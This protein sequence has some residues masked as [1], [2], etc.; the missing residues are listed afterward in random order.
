[1]R[2]TL[3]ITTLFG[4]AALA[5]CSDDPANVSGDYTVSVANRD[6][7]CNISN[8]NVGESVFSSRRLVS[9]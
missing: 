6:N 9:L 3:A 1:M 8:W 2:G 4:L 7:G 5:G